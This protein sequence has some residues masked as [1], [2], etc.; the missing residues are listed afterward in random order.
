MWQYILIALGALLVLLLLVLVVRTLRF[1]RRLP[2]FKQ[3]Q[4]PEVDGEMA[5]LHL[6]A[7]IRHATV[8]Y[9][10]RARI[11]V[12]PFEL[13]SHDLER[14][15]PS[16]HARLDVD[17]LNRYSLLYT[18]RGSDQ[19]LKPV[20]FAS[21]LDVV[22]VEGGT[23]QQWTW[24]PFDGRVED[25]AVWGRGALDN[26]H[27][28][29][30]I[31]EAVEMLVRQGWQ[32]RRTILLAFGHD[33][34]VGGRQ[35]AQGIAAYLKSEGI[36]LEALIDEGGAI[37]REGLPGLKKPVALVGVAEKGYASVELTVEGSGGH[38]SMP[39]RVTPIGSLSALLADIEES[40]FPADLDFVTAM[41]KAVGR[42][43]PFG[44]RMAFAN[45]WLLGGIIRR[46]LE[47]K[48]TTNALIRTTAALTI[49][50]AGV[51]DNV[52]PA[53]A[54]AVV[55]FRL[56]PG[57]TLDDV[58][59]FI[60]GLA[61]QGVEINLLEEGAWEAAKPS[62]FKSPAAAG[63]LR[64][65]EE[66]YPEALPAPYLVSG[67]TDSRHYAGI[68]EQIYRFSPCVMTMKDV[69]SV[70]SVNEHISVESLA[71][72]VQFYVRLMHNWCG[73]TAAGTN[74]KRP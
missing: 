37:F 5:A 66:V 58:R 8:S 24:P 63:L 68:C 25:G 46:E 69:Q 13:L 42:A 16:L 54:R 74:E 3:A 11:D 20:L 19:N 47:A 45:R 1:G 31:L 53:R 18:W 39:P 49:F 60:R 55:N 67:A 44:L 56:F 50:N 14:M 70:H 32:P 9:E 30:A 62:S 59:Q 65:L 29:I 33:E 34:E 15:F 2:R 61:P 73:E 64:S 48:P 72:M 27:T 21:H 7:A 43:L 6:G 38:S 17:E 22:P 41:F 26:K 51:K 36:Q 4:L 35:G 12:R 10:D 40:P 52:L 57:D 23:M 71:R 28:L